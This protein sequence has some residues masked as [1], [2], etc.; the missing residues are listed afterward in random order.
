[1]QEWSDVLLPS[2]RRFQNVDT[3]SSLNFSVEEAVGVLQRLRE[4]FG[5]SSV[6]QQKTYIA[7]LPPAWGRERIAH[8]F[9]GTHHQ[10][11]KS[12]ERRS[13]A[14]IVQSYEDQRGNK[15]LDV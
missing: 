7:I 8:W 10:A 13:N 11:R 2:S 14:E 9:G 3:L 6:E 1:M 12:I 15:L 4:L 5:I